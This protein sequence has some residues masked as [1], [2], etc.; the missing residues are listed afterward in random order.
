[1]NGIAEPGTDLAIRED[2]APALRLPA[3]PSLP[4]TDSWIRAMS[5]IAKLAAQICN[6]SFVPKGL[7]GDDA[8]VTAAILT[9]RELGLPPMAALR[10]I[11]VVEGTPSLDA[12]YKRAKVLSLG[13][14]FDILEW[15][16]D[17]CVVSGRRKG[18]RKPP[19]I[20]SYTMND[21][22]R[23]QLVKERG[24]YLTR[25]KVMMLARATTLI[26]NAIFAD[27]TNGLATTELLEAG[28]E[29]AI[30]DAIGAALEIPAPQR[31]RVTAGQA[32]E[33]A[34]Q[35]RQQVPGEVIEP[36]RPGCPEALHDP[37]DGSLNECQLLG[38]HEGRH[39]S[40]VITWGGEQPA[41][42]EP[43]SSPFGQGDPRNGVIAQFGR[44][45]VTSTPGM[46][47]RAARLLGIAVPSLDSL[48]ADEAAALIEK[49]AGCQATADLEAALAA[50][51]DG[52]VP[53]GQ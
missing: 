2:T 41:P 52:T 30:A 50:R 36:D 31:P 33:H 22:R 7:R 48:G 1:M 37:G 28:D 29:D 10:H 11:H 23:A 43:V 5:S 13:H 27:V 19:L 15:D 26:C 38:G 14:E 53:G 34:Q 16:N 21:A 40:G 47:A 3:L 42:A 32:R 46:C 4:D 39:K 20:V 35:S 25:P 51:A 9:G 18:S 12:E 49:L 6:T 45:G 44:L 17:H 24:N 8:A